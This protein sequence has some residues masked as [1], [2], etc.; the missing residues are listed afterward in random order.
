MNLRKTLLRLTIGTLLGAGAAAAV[1]S[2]SGRPSIVPNSDK[3]LRR[4]SAQF[5]A[6]SAKRHPYKAE[7]PRGGEAAARAQVGYMLD[8]IE[9]VNLSDE[10]WSDVE[11]WVNQAYVVHIPQMQRGR[12]KRLNFQMIFDD[13]GHYLP[14]DKIRVTKVEVLREGKMYDIPVQLAD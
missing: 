13:Q 3:S 8:Q 12:L 2:C 9:V 4:S 1:I 7:V 5:A 14:T 6:D 11:L 10:D